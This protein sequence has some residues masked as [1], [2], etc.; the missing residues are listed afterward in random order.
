MS[1]IRSKEA[2]AKILSC[3]KEHI[4]DN[5]KHIKAGDHSLAKDHP[6]LKQHVR[7]FE[8]D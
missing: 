7:V 2:L 6:V 1:K 3:S 4:E 8:E 5:K